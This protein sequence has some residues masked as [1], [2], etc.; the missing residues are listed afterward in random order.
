MRRLMP[1]LVVLAALHCEAQ[2][3]YVDLNTATKAELESLPGIGERMSSEIIQRRPIAVF[4][5]LLAIPNFGRSRLERI[6]QLVSIDGAPV[7]AAA[8]RQADEGPAARRAPTSARPPRRPAAS[9]P[10]EGWSVP[11]GMTANRC[12]RCEES[13]CVEAGTD[14]GICPYCG[15]RWAR[16]RTQ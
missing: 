12:W 16:R 3:Q 15:I 6:R 4:E 14:E 9:E 5:D 8:V 1:A 13:F 10:P 2:A 7:P 11:A